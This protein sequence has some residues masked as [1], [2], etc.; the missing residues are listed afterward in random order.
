[1]T[2]EEMKSYIINATREFMSIRVLVI[3]GGECFTIGEDLDRIIN[4]GSQIGLI[5]RVVTNAY[6]ADTYDNAYKR[7]F[8]LKEAGLNEFNISTGKNHQQFIKSEN[9]KN[10]AIAAVNLGFAPIQIA[11]E[12]HPE[13]TSDYEQWKKDDPIPELIEENKIQIISGPWMDFKKHT[14]R[15]ASHK[16][17]SKD[18]DGRC[19]NLFRSLTINP[20]SELL[21]CCG[22]T[23]EYIPYFKLGNLKI[24]N[25]KD[26]Y[27]SQFF[28][29]YLLWLYTYG[30]K[31]IYELLNKT[32]GGI[33][34]QFPHPC[35]Y[36]IEI[37]QDKSN[38]EILRNLIHDYVPSI[39]YRLKM[40][41]NKFMF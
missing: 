28:D 21:A 35:A 14:N 22:L 24:T 40:I 32:K 8:S 5:T 16:V 7:L 31:A 39:L 12:V 30:P 20:Y 23:V 34:K 15:N 19:R 36:C 10:A 26:L 37:I 25:I 38:I 11:C 3:T 4:F 13:D 18:V 2:Y 17:I 9:I 33:I 6:W 1:M 41:N 27:D 29:L